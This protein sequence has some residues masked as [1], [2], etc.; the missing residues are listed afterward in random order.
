MFHNTIFPRVIK[1]ILP[2]K[3]FSSRVEMSSVCAK[4]EERL[5]VR[6]T[7]EKHLKTRSLKM[8][9]EIAPQKDVGKS[10]FENLAYTSTQTEA[11]CIVAM[12]SL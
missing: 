12:Q 10:C 2:A 3:E 6:Q 1:G 5:L 7:M 4:S 8:K 9:S 11:K